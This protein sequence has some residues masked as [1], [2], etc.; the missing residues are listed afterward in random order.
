M[1]PTRKN[2]TKVKDLPKQ[3]VSSRKAGVVKGGQ[4]L[5]PT[6]KPGTPQA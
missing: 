4:R 6:P 5:S 2:G 1:S 3:P